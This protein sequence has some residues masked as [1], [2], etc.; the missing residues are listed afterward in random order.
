M[1][2][3][4]LACAVA[5]LLAGCANVRGKELPTVKPGDPTWSL[6]PDHLEYGALPQ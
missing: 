1:R 2:A 6:V 5:V 3:L 4:V